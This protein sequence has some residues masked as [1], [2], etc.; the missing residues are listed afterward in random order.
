MAMTAIASSEELSPTFDTSPRVIS[1][2]PIASS[3]SRETSES[4]KLLPPTFDTNNLDRDSP[5][6][7]SNAFAKSTSLDAVPIAARTF[8]GSASRD[9]LERPPHTFD[10]DSMS[11]QPFVFVILLLSILAT[12]HQKVSFKNMNSKAALFLLLL[13]Q[14]LIHCTARKYWFFTDAKTGYDAAADCASRGSTLATVQTVSDSDLT[15]LRNSIYDTAFFQSHAGLVCYHQEGWHR[16]YT[17]PNQVMDFDVSSFWIG[18]SRTGTVWGWDDGSACIVNHELCWSH[19]NS[20]EPSNTGGTEDRAELGLTT[21]WNDVFKDS[22]VV[23]G[24]NDATQT[25]S[26]PYACNAVSRTTIVWR[27]LYVF[28]SNSDYV[29]TTNKYESQSG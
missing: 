2:S 27:D 3:I 18:L 16:T 12:H 28:Q 11:N 21:N 25:G 10:Y 4:S 8:V 13:S 5:M 9:S 20:G 23:G 6:A 29:Y 17:A 19:W 7:F 1:Y 24:A 14:S 26:K 15:A 22:V